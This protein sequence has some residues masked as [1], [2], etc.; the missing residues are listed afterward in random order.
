[1]FSTIYSP[2]TMSFPSPHVHL[3]ELM[4]SFMSLK[5]SLSSSIQ[6]A[7]PLA[8]STSFSLLYRSLAFLIKPS[9]A[10]FFS[11]LTCL[12]TPSL[13][14]HTSRVQPGITMKLSTSSSS[15]GPLQLDSG[16][17]PLME[18]H[19]LPWPFLGTTKWVSPVSQQFSS[20]STAQAPVMVEFFLALLH[21]D[22][23]LLIKHSPWQL[24][25]TPSRRR[26][27]YFIMLRIWTER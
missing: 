2:P 22:E 3:Y 25:R 8:L 17:R 23:H 6:F 18:P 4:S 10:D 26:A 16:L 21:H 1:M 12:S 15:L 9:L 11:A 5:S 24:L 19:I 7:S 14:S 20:N 13:S 27:V